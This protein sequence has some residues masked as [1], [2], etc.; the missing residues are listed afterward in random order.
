VDLRTA[1]KEKQFS[2]EKTL[3]GQACKEVRQPHYTVKLE[4]TPYLIKQFDNLLVKYAYYA[5][6]CKQSPNTKGWGR[7]PAVI[8]QFGQINTDHA[9]FEHGYS[10]WVVIF[11]VRCGGD[12]PLSSIVQGLDKASYNVLY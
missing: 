12:S 1:S 4:T 2:I 11:V 10:D 3:L 7:Q 9:Q 8:V 6:K 5:Y